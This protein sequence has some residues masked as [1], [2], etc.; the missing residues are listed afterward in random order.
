MELEIIILCKLTQT[1]SNAHEQRQQ[2]EQRLKDG[3]SED[4]LTWGSSLSAD[5]KPDIVAIAKRHL[6]TRQ[7]DMAVPW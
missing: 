5:T 6:L 2:M 1:Q 4:H 3:P 7:G